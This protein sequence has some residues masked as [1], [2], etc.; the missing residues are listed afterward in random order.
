MI[1][2]KEIYEKIGFIM[3]IA[4]TLEYNL[5]TIIAFS[6]IEKELRYRQLTNEE[7]KRKIDT[8]EEIY[9]ELNR[10][11][12]GFSIELARE[13]KIFTEEFLETLS[14]A[15]HSRNYYAH[16]FFKEDIKK[17]QIN[18][19][20]EKVLNDLNNNITRLKNVNNELADDLGILKAR[21][22]KLIKR[23]E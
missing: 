3:H 21:I 14:K 9:E 12:L 19:N 1:D 22:N 13:T 2:N 4:Q 17:N 23:E 6:K 18:S 8:I 11:P 16:R 20:K 5:S 15:L 10:K 7:I